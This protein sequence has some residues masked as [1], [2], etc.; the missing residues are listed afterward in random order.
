MNRQQTRA[1]ES[2]APRR[3]IL[4][5]VESSGQAVVAL[6]VCVGNGSTAAGRGGSKGT[7]TGGS[8]CC[9][10]FC[11]NLSYRSYRI[12]TLLRSSFT[13]RSKPKEKI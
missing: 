1:G 5:L 7:A 8:A 6:P 13:L 12:N 3:L 2:F 4:T 11:L 9:V 10:V